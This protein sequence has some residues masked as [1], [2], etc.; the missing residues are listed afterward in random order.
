MIV[1]CN[2][3]HGGSLPPRAHA[4]GY[5]SQSRFNLSENATYAVHGIGVVSGVTCYLLRDDNG[6]PNWIPGAVFEILDPTLPSGWAFTYFHPRGDVPGVMEALA[7][8]V[9][10]VEDPSMPDA[11]MAREGWAMEIFG[12]LTAG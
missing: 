2:A 6:L 10:V 4:A 5:T 12:R 1:R 9:E 3:T 8:Y 11:L 7:S